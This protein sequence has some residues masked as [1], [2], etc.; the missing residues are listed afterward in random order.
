MGRSLIFQRRGTEAVLFLD[1]AKE[2][3]PLHAETYNLL[4]AVYRLGGDFEAVVEARKQALAFRPETR[5][6]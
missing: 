5:H 6:F 4:A 2:V 3:D 1:I